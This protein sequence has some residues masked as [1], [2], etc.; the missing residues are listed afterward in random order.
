[1]ID[2]V[3]LTHLLAKWDATMKY[4]AENRLR[5]E[6]DRK[7]EG[8]ALKIRVRQCAIA[9]CLAAVVMHSSSNTAT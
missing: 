3:G 4:G 6:Q 7:S 9:F 2:F 1:M 5:V 8:P